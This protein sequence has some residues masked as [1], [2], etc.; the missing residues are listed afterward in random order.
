MK[1]NISNAELSALN[2][3]TNPEFP[4]YTSQLINWANQ[5]AQGTRPRIVGQLSDLFPEYQASTYNI[6]ISD[7]E[8][9]YTEKYP[10][11]IEEAT[12]KIFNQ[13]E[14]LKEAIKLID[15]SMVRKWVEDLVISKT[16][17]GMYV[18]RAILAK[19]SDMREEPFRLA[20]PEEESKGIDGYVGDTAY[21]IKPVTYKTMGRLSESIDIKMIYYSKKKSGLLVETEE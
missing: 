21:S 20:S 12:D 8:E 9:W 14:N 6:A 13:V 15:K 3:I 10:D 4:K 18:Q 7:W 19:I 16:F 1:F 2:D 11:A 5:N 17:S